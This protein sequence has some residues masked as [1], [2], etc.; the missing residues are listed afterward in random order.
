M[1]ATNDLEPPVRYSGEDG[2]CDSGVV[3]VIKMSSTYCLTVVSGG[4]LQHASS[5]STWL[6]RPGDR[7]IPWG[8]LVYLKA[9]PCHVNEKMP[10]QV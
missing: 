4:S 9:W 10:L 3:A 2:V 1:D 8:N 5:F 6:N 7:E